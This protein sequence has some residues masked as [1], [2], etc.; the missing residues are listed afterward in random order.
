MIYYISRKEAKE[1][2]FNNKHLT[3]REVFSLCKL[4]TWEVL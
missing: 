1:I 4:Y 2:A 3:L